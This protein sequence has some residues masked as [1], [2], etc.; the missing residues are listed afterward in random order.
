MEYDGMYIPDPHRPS[1][2]MKVVDLII[3]F[4]TSLA[5]ITVVVWCMWIAQLINEDGGLI[6]FLFGPSP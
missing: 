1:R 2:I 5:A 4:I 3:I 6:N